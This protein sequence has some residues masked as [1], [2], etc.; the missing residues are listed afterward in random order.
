MAKLIAFP[1]YESRLCGWPETVRLTDSEAKAMERIHLGGMAALRTP[2]YKCACR[3]V[4]ALVKK[5]LLGKDGPTMLG[6]KV[7][8]ACAQPE[9]Y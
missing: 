3:T 9:S 1:I 6:R 8:E 2:D 5:G 7:A 4:D